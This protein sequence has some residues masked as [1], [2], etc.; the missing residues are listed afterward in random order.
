MG[1]L[2][3]PYPSRYIPK[4]INDSPSV[5]FARSL[6]VAL[7]HRW[8]SE[9]IFVFVFTGY[10]DESGTHGTS[11]VT[12]MGG[13]LARAQQWERFEHLFARLQ[14]RHG[15]RVFHTKKF[16]GSKGD[17]RGWTGDQKRARYWDLAAL[18]SQGPTEC[19]AMAL[20]NES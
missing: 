11:P 20:E 15:F 5:G 1:M 13:M 16:K 12:V 14:N 17:F 2:D 7:A 19:V 9:R 4:R 18:T 10:L 3:L 6:C 8:A